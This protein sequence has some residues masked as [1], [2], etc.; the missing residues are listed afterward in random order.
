MN[1]HRD[2]DREGANSF[3]TWLT[4]VNGFHRHRDSLSIIA[5]AIKHFVCEQLPS[6]LVDSELCPLLIGLLHDGVLHLPVHALVLVQGVYFDHRTTVWSAF[7]NFRSIRRA[8]LKY[9]FVVLKF[10]K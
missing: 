6:L 10:Q 4:G 3:E 7:F 1:T 8:I 2:F 9:G 5:L